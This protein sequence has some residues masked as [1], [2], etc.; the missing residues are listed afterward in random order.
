MFLESGI[1]SYMGTLKDALYIYICIG[2]EVL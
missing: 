1:K 2:S